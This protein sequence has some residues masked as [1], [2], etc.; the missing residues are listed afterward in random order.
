[1]PW[2]GDACT[3]KKEGC[4][5]LFGYSARCKVSVHLIALVHNIKAH[6]K[7]IAI[8]EISKEGERNHQM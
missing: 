3:V 7:A 2:D 6:A 1:M 4:G 5:E 8:F